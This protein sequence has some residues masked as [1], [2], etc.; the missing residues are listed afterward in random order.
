MRTGLA[1]VA[2]LGVVALLGAW[3]AVAAGAAPDAGARQLMGGVTPEH[4]LDFVRLDPSRASD[5]DA[6]QLLAM[7]LDQFPPGPLQ[8]EG[9]MFVAEAWRGR[10]HRPDDALPLLRAVRDDPAAPAV[11]ARLAAREIVDTLVDERRLDEAAAEADAHADLL[12]PAFVRLTHKIV[13]RR[14]IRV[15][16]LAELGGFG[17]LVALALSRGVRRGSLGTAGTAV[18][19][20]VPVAIL[21]AAYLAGLGGVLASRYETGNAT[22]FVALGLLVL[23]LSLLARAWGAVGSPAA[24][25]RAGRALLCAVSVL[26]AAF[27][28]LDAVNPTYLEGFG[29]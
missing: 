9:R 17:G 18:R 21:F 3:C 12:D 26:A 19:R 24:A 25:A 14:T 7:D 28:L 1:A 20:I 4:R 15:I 11:T 27:L 6:I 23:P 13:S 2:L 16:A 5:P 8:V 22:P 29:L 10:L